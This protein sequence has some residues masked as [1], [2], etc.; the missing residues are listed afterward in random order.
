MRDASWIAVAG[1]ALAPAVL[2]LAALFR[3]R[4]ATEDKAS[5]ILAARR[6]VQWNAKERRR[7]GGGSIRGQGYGGDTNRAYDAG[8]TSDSGGMP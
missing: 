2:V 7:R 5:A 4:R 8:A 1:T 6:A 3:R